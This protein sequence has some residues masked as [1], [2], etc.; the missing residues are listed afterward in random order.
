MVGM[1]LQAVIAAHRVRVRGI[2]DDFPPPVNGADVPLL[3]VNVALG[4]Y[5]DE[6]LST[7]LARIEAAGFTWVRQTFY[8][9]QIETPSGSF[10][11]TAADRVVAALAH[12]PDL[13]LIAVLDESASAPPADPDRFAAFGAAFAARYS[14]QV[15]AYQIWDEPN[16][17]E[18]WG[19]GPVNPPAYADLLARTASA[20]RR[21]DADAFIL[22]AGLAP[23]VETGPQNLSDAR[24]L[25]RL[26]EAGAAPYFDAVAGKPYGFYSGPDDRRVDDGLLNFSRLILLRE[27][28]LAYGDADKAVWA[29]H[30]GW[31]ALPDDWAGTPS[32]WGGTDEATQAAYTVAALARAR[33]EWPWVGA[34][35][36]EHFQPAVAHDG[37]RWGFALVGPDGALRPVYEA[38]SAWAEALPDAAPPGGYPARNPWVTYRGDWQVGPLGADVGADVGGEMNTATFRFD[39]SAVALTVRRGPYRGFLYVTVD[40]APANGLPRDQDG[41]AYLVLYDRD[42]AV[43]T[44]TLARDLAPG[45]HTVEVLAEGGEGQ[46]SV[47]DW[48]VASA[49][50]IARPGHIAYTWPF[51]GLLG[52]GLALLTLLVRDV[53]RVDWEALKHRCLAWPEGAQAA[54][55]GGMTG[56]LWFAAAASWGRDWASPCFVVSLFA[57]VGLILLFAARLDLGLAM[58]ALTA[59]FYLH[60]AGMFYG[61][62]SLPQALIVLC[63]IAWAIRHRKHFALAPR[64]LARALAASSWIDRLVI[65]W[66]GAATVAALAATDRRAAFFELLTVFFIPALYYVLLRSTSLDAGVR[67]RLV[68]AFLLGGVGV[69]AIGLAQYARG[70]HVVIAEGGLPRLQ[71]VYFSPNRV[72]LYLGRV[73][74]LFLVLL[75]GSKRRTGWAF[76]SLAVGAAMVAVALVLSFSRGA[77][78]LGIPAALLAMGIAAGGRYR[79]VVVVLV[80][81]QALALIPLLQVP[82]FASLFDLQQGSTFFRLE[83]WR[84]TLALLREHPWLGVGP[85]N[86]LAAYRTRYVLPTAWQEFNLQH[87]HNIYLDLW[88][89]LGIPGLLTGGALLLTILG[90]FVPALRRRCMDSSDTFLVLGLLGS[91]VALLAHGLVDNALFFP[92]MATVFFLTAALMVCC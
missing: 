52:A 56:L 15:A 66:L 62:L 23:T 9:D 24:Y 72:G 71:S 75:V 65:G 78:L 79:R 41:R 34:M 54:L 17:A 68:Y 31:N 77:L 14:A 48:R 38:V 61:A 49:P 12:F 4:Q 46:W 43:A 76:H 36:L 81:I 5:D 3:G 30:W 7:A 91:F 55:I 85:G 57:S 64:D 59:P 90:R 35:V 2:P 32:P 60:P 21:A 82:R 50:M 18:R 27:V 26:Y 92:D 69:A 19:G 11:W 8:W 53:R 10:D 20:I 1:G 22:T 44:V 87:P 80:V 58:V 86:F 84:S 45:L 6:A 70:V 13:R 33:A 40:G 67:W 42:L 25:A 47:I 63:A 89:S 74:P 39:G 83:L 16:L 88:A 28:M 73:L 29:S 37:P 51:I